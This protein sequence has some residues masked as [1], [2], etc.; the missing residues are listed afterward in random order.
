[1]TYGGNLI[2]RNFATTRVIRAMQ[3]KLLPAPFNALKT[4]LKRE[5]R[6]T[7]K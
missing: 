2:F 3:Y 7:T 1:M 5:N 4:A 6:K